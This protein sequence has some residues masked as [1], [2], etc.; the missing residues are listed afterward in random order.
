MFIMAARSETSSPGMRMG[1][2]ASEPEA[3]KAGLAHGVLSREAALIHKIEPEQALICWS[4]ELRRTMFNAFVK[5]PRRQRH[6]GA[7]PIER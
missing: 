2:T 6:E 4:L 7:D 5:Q 1:L 3:R